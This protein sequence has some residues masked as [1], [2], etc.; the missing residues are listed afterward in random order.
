M[1]A[2]VLAVFCGPLPAQTPPTASEPAGTGR[3]VPPPAELSPFS[4]IGTRLKPAS[5]IEFRPA[6]QMTERDRLLLAGAE[7]SITERS[8]FAGFDFDKT[9]WSYQQVVCRALPNHLFLQFMRNNGTGDLTVFSA[10][11]P[12]GGEGR[13]RIIPILKRGY[14]LWSPA[15]VNSMT[16]SAF[17]H[18]RA[19]EARANETSKEDPEW[20]GNALCYAALAGAHPQVRAADAEPNLHKPIPAVTAVMDVTPSA[21]SSQVIRFADAAALPRP[22]LWT[23]TFTRQGKLIKATHALAPMTSVRL[24]PVAKDEE[25]PQP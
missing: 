12:R 5:G 24:V 4:T 25:Q 14:S 10:S 7:A 22:M 23:M 19:E 17:N 9:N 1:T 13:V 2:A 11:I 18:I 8:T 6:D 3:Q 20:L 16:I 15:P 21:K